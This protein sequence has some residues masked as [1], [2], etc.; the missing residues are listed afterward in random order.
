MVSPS[1]LDLTNLLMNSARSNTAAEAR[2]LASAP[3]EM[4]GAMIA[5]LLMQKEQE[6]MESIAKMMKKAGEAGKTLRR[7]IGG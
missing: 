5:Q 3:P 2:W 1:I 7:N 4:Q 6:L